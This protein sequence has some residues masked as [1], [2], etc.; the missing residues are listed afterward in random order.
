[1]KLGKCAVKNFA[2]Y[3]E[4]EI[5]FSDKGLVLI[6]GATG[7]GKSTLQDIPCWILFGQT[8]KGGLVDDI[9]NWQ[10]GEE[11][12]SGIL[13]VDLPDGRITVCRLRGKGKNDLYWIDGDYPGTINRGKDLAETQKRL[14]QKLRCDSTL[15]TSATYFHE[16]SPTATFFSSNSKQ[17][18]ELFECVADISLPVKLLENIPFRKKTLKTDFD[19]LHQARSYTCGQSEAIARRLSDSRKSFLRWN[20]EQSKLL[21][22]LEEKSQQFDLEKSNQISA[23]QKQYQQED[24]EKSKKIDLWLSQVNRLKSDP[25]PKNYDS[26]INEL[27]NHLRCELCGSLS[28]QTHA[29]ISQLE[30]EKS[31]HIRAMADVDRICGYISDCSNSKNSF[32]SA[33]ETSLSSSN[34]YPYLLEKEKLKTNPF[35]E[36]VKN[37]EQELHSLSLQLFEEQNNIKKVEYDILLLGCL[38]DLSHHLRSELLSRVIIQIQDSTNRYIERYFDGELSVNF[39]L[40]EAGINVSVQK[41]GFTCSYKQLSKGQRQILKLCFGVAVMEESA[42]N[43]GILFQNLFFDESLDGLDTELKLKAFSLFEE[44]STR[45]G[46]VMVIDHA[47]EL[48]QQFQSK[49]RVCLDNDSSIL[50]YES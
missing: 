38:G 42:N 19:R 32:E 8:A 45:H 5:D 9:R 29:K 1:M 34:H 25:K 3:R 35:G 39:S 2:S 41:S 28:E 27:K 48:Q 44:L 18:R 26:Y 15:F 50:D 10:A 13:T 31:E 43:S 11:I 24:N 30:Q 4:L 20:D 6:Y 21:E 16:F 46:T 23:L 7:S 22:H 47:P 14:V 17:Q 37:C 12:T 40:E 49:I 36:C 33:I